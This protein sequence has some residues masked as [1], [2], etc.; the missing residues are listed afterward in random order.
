M[1]GDLGWQGKALPIDENDIEDQN[2]LIFTETAKGQQRTVIKL[3]V[4]P[5]AESKILAELRKATK[6]VTKIG[7]RLPEDDFADGYSRR[8]EDSEPPRG[9]RQLQSV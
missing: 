1:P 2:A 5:E 7:E 6:Q 8:R 9:G 4:R 3:K